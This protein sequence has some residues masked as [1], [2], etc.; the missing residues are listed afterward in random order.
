MTLHVQVKLTV[1]TFIVIKKQEKQDQLVEASYI[2]NSEYS[3]SALV[4]KLPGVVM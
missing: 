3:T 2:N 4:Q 1:S